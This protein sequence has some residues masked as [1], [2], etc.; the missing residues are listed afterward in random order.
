MVMMEM[1]R[2]PECLRLRR[3][4]IKRKNMETYW[5]TRKVSLRA[6]HSMGERRYSMKA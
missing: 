1:R 3:L 2:I 5:S 6:F 4:L